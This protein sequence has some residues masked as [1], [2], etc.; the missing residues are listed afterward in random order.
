MRKAKIKLKKEHQ[1]RPSV[2]RNGH[3]AHKSVPRKS[4]TAKK[5]AKK[6]YAASFNRYKFYK[7][8][9]YT[10]TT[11]GRRQKW[12]Y[13][14]GEWKDRKITPGG[15]GGAGAGAGRRAG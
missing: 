4:A 14:K 9:Q 6:N 12:Y 13:D 11:I 3:A 8:K 15:G 5:P 7:G 1:Y 10:G 2:R